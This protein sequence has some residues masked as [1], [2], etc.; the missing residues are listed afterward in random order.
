L[1]AEET[2]TMTIRCKFKVDTIKRIQSSKSKQ[3]ENGKWISEPVEMRSVEMSPVYSTDPATENKQFWD[4][5]PSGQLRFDTVN[6]K[7]VEGL[8]LGAEYYID[9]TPAPKP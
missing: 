6:L 9:I 3:D 5:T 2:N 1:I 8:E 7:A 4:A